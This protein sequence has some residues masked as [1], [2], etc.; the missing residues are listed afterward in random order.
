[1]AATHQHCHARNNSVYDVAIVGAG[2]NALRLLHCLKEQTG[3]SLPLRIV[4]FEREQ[5]GHTIAQWYDGSVSHS[6]R[7]TF[8]IGDSAPTECRQCLESVWDGTYNNDNT[9]RASCVSDK[10]NWHCGRDEYLAYMQ[11]MVQAYVLSVC[12]YERV[13]SIRP[14]VEP[15]S[16]SNTSTLFSVTTRRRNAANDGTA[17]ATRNRTYLA[18]NVVLAFGAISYPKSIP[19][20]DAA[21]SARV[22]NALGNSAEYRDKHV[23]V[24][25]TGPS[26]METAVRLCSSAYRAKHVTLA[27]RSRSLM[28][29]W[30]LYINESLWRI[31]DFERRGRLTLLLQANLVGAN[32]THAVLR[33]PKNAS[34]VHKRSRAPSPPVPSKDVEVRADSII[35]AVGFTSDEALIRTV[36]FKDGKLDLGSFETSMRGVFNVGIKGVSPW[37]SKRSA[38]S[39]LSTFIE[40]S[41]PQV[42]KVCDAVVRR[43]RGSVGY[44]ASRT[45]DL[46]VTSGALRAGER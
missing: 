14:A 28:F 26:G 11:R 34:A 40:D 6:A 37:A 42:R 7:N 15:S 8:Q 29:A 5:I 2:P 21:S 45:A 33:L 13:L 38:S 22:T 23:L 1:M 32:T 19:L 24:M 46:A 43:V 3:S 27:T 35:T 30:N 31:H 16:A 12:E 44:S 10:K 36:G 20:P 41:M 4:T 25:G 17:L 9:S 39:R 18:S